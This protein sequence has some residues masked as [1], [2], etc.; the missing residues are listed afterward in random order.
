MP[1][2]FGEDLPPKSDMVTGIAQH[3]GKGCLLIPDTPAI[4]VERKPDALAKCPMK[5]RKAV[6]RLHVDGSVVDQ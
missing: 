2:P 6:T 4:G 1:K 5:P 3:D